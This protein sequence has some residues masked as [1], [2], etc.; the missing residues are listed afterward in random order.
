MGG[1]EEDVRVL[2]FETSCT[3]DLFIGCA[4][5]TLKRKKV[6]LND[7]SYSKREVNFEK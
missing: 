4:L 3:H 2:L 7:P 1:E 6:A 5:I